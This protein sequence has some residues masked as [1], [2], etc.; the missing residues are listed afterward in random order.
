MKKSLIKRM[1]K[2]IGIILITSIVSNIMFIGLMHNKTEQIEAYRSF[3]KE[4][5][6]RNHTVSS[7]HTA[8]TISYED[9]GYY[10][11]VVK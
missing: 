9:A 6:D 5:Y 4:S 10:N 11:H 2:L 8:N 3:F 7:Y 1:K